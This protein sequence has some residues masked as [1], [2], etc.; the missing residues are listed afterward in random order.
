VKYLK[1]GTHNVL[2]PPQHFTNGNNETA[3]INP[4]EAFARKA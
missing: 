2:V 3:L 4:D 1:E